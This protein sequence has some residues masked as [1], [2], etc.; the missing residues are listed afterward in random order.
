M[1]SN[2]KGKLPS[3]KS[4]M[5][6][7]LAQIVLF[8][9][10]SLGATAIAFACGDPTGMLGICTIA[11]LIV[12]A[13]TGGAVLSRLFGGG[14][15]LASAACITIIYLAISLIASGSLGINHLINAL[16][17][18]AASCLGSIIGTKRRGKRRRPKRK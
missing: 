15:A 17:H 4:I 9:S 14:S 5:I 10:V 16:C 1:I 3:P 6:G 8:L 18:I 2:S 13:L 12:S 11:A 7:T